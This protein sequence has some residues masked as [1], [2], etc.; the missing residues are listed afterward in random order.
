[1]YDAFAICTA[2]KIAD[3]DMR[4]DHFIN[5]STLRLKSSMVRHIKLVTFLSDLQ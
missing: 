3:N 4:F 1:M 5:S 2:C